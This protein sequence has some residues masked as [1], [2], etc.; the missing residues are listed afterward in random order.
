VGLMDRLK[1]LGCRLGLVR[2][3]TPRSAPRKITPRVTRLKDLMA[4]APHPDL[5]H[6]SDDPSWSL[7]KVFERA[8]IGQRAWTVERVRDLLRTERFRSMDRPTARQALLQVLAA[9]KTG[10]DDLVQDARLRDRALAEAESRALALVNQRS[11]LRR[12][13][14]EALARQIGQLKETCSAMD[15]ANQDDQQDLCQWQ[16]RKV[17]Y[18]KDMAWALGFLTENPGGIPADPRKS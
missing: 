1:D 15:A 14:K 4:E 11:E 5:G 9:E 10:V 2:T 16:D 13:K 7:D 18:A 3:R 6:L 8:G 17:A 12:Q